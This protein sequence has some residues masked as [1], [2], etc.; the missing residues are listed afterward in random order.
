MGDTKPAQIVCERS[1]QMQSGAVTGHFPRCGMRADRILKESGPVTVLRDALS[2]CNHTR[3]EIAVA[4]CPP[5][6]QAISA[7]DKLLSLE[8]YH[9]PQNAPA[10]FPESRGGYGCRITARQSGRWGER[11]EA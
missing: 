10:G 7:A 6:K 11:F 4:L 9:S 1:P 3:K 5:L 8:G 2:K